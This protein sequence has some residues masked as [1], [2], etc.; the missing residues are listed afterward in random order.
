MISGSLALISLS[1]LN[2]RA[3][4][5]TRVDRKYI[6]GDAMLDR[7]LTVGCRNYAML[8]IEGRSEFGYQSVYFDTHDLRLYRDAATRRRRRFKVRTR[9]YEDSG[10]AVLEVKAKDGHS[11][12]VKH[13]LDYLS[14]DR[15]RL[16]EHGLDFIDEVTGSTDISAKLAPVLTTNYRRSTLVD[17]TAETRITIDRGL[18][19]TD[20]DGHAVGLDSVIIETKSDRSAGTLDRWLWQQGVRPVSI[21]K[22]CTSMAVMRPELPSNK[23]HRTID[24]H[25]R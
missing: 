9:V 22:Y 8:D 16:T 7:L 25:F 24:R 3:E 12:T 1:E 6:L 21:S 23:W 18:V 2:E 19:C 13:R 11:R 4:L 20:A 5:L 15:R 14:N 17:L 10:V